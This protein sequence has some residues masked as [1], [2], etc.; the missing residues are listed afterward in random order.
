METKQPPQIKDN[1]GNSQ[2]SKDVMLQNANKTKHEL[3]IST[4]RKCLQTWRLI[5]RSF[6]STQYSSRTHTVLLKNP[7]NNKALFT[8]DF[9]GV[10]SSH[11]IAVK[12]RSKITFTSKERNWNAPST[13]TPLSRR[14]LLLFTIM[15]LG[16]R[17]LCPVGRGCLDSS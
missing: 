12:S 6:C 17:W 3:C 1:N 14:K 15:E 5:P 2:K 11:Q 16:S 13:S 4:E 7:W 10:I 8:S 9:F